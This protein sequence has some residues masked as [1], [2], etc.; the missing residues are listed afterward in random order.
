MK[1]A[2]VQKKEEKNREMAEFRR[3]K[4]IPTIFLG[5]GAKKFTNNCSLVSK[6][7]MISRKQKKAPTESNEIVPGT[8]SESGQSGKLLFFL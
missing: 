1:M 5:V 6:M 3:K 7:S 2:A 8:F 4:Y